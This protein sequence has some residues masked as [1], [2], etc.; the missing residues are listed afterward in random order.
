MHFQNTFPKTSSIF[1][2]QKIFSFLCFI[3]PKYFSCNMQ[4]EVTFHALLSLQKKLKHLLL[5]HVI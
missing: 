5:T 2:S 1:W 3:T 4:L